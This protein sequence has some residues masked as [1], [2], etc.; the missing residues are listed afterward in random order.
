[1]LIVPVYLEIIKQN[2]DRFYWK[3]MFDYIGGFGFPKPT[4]KIFFGPVLE[5]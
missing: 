2:K 4:H 1:M 5:I 3:E